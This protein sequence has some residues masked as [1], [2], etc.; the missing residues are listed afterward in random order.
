MSSRSAVAVVLLM[1]LACGSAEDV[2]PPAAEPAAPAELTI[3][4]SDNS[5]AAPDTVAP[6]VTRIRLINDGP[7]LHHAILIRIDSGKT[8]ADVQAALAAGEEPAWAVLIGGDGAADPGQEVTT[9]ADLAPG[10]YVLACFLQNAPDQPPHVAL[11]MLRP[12]VVAGT[13]GTATLPEATAEVELVDFDFVLPQLTAGPQMIR[14][15]NN[16]RESHE[17]MLF[18][19]PEGMSMEQFQVMLSS[20]EPGGIESLGGNGALSPGNSNLWQVTLTPGTYA[21]VC[22]VPSPSDKTPH[23]MKGMVKSF[24]VAAAS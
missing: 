9:F 8:M 21:A 7:H 24:T 19:L 15:V 1:S 3:R 10:N 20:A 5:F 4:T 13:A 16:G 6:G 22:F 14:V 23:L 18:R 11:G 12:L 2:P 17:I